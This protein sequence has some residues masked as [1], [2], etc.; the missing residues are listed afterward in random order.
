MLFHILLARND[1][2]GIIP[3]MGKFTT[4]I[5][6]FENLR[7]GGYVYVGKTD[8]LRRIAADKEGRQFFISRPR[9]FD[10]SP[11]AICATSSANRFSR[12]CEV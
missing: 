1:P 11:K 4:D 7:K 12:S 3:D 6:S 9:R 2:Y 5:Y 8:F 10:K